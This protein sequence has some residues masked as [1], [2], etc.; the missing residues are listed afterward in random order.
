[1]IQAGG[2]VFLFFF[3]KSSLLGRTGGDDDDDAK[4]EGED[5]VEVPRGGVRAKAQVERVDCIPLHCRLLSSI[6]LLQ[7]SVPDAARYWV[8]TFFRFF[9]SGHFYPGQEATPAA[10][11][12]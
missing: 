10:V 11:G 6:S 8:L 7:R 12:L 2:A 9:R 4:E 1:M 3:G 5:D